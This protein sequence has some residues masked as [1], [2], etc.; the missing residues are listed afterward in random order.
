MPNGKTAQARGMTLDAAR[1][2]NA[3]KA[4]AETARVIDES[5]WISELQGGARG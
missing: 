3:V 2:P 5:L 1:A 4:G